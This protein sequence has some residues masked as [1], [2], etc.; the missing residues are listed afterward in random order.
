MPSE[1]IE[2]HVYRMLETK[3]G[4]R[5]LA[6]ENAAILVNS[7][8]KLSSEDNDVAVFYNIFKNRIGE[9]FVSVQ[10]ELS[11][12]IDDLITVQI[13]EKYPTKS[14]TDVKTEQ[15]KKSDIGLTEQVIFTT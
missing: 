15:T 2:M 8:E 14:Q 12:S 4:L 9:D 7:L 13:M 10:A 6:I 1:S 11:R 3:Y 5:S